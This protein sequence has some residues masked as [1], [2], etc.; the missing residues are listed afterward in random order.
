MTF[1]QGLGFLCGSLT[2]SGPF[3]KLSPRTLL[4]GGRIASGLM[5]TGIFIVP[6]PTPVAV[7]MMAL[8]AWT[9]ALSTIATTLVLANES[10]AGHAATMTLNGS[11]WSVG[12][13]IGASLGGI[14]LALGGW[15]ALGA[16]GLGFFLVAAGLGW[17]SG[18][19]PR[20]SRVLAA[21]P[22]PR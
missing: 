12:I 10:P 7:L 5:M 4:V 3:G 1:V 15:P 8:G 18:T 9:G 6:A 22:R 17:L 20:P 14:V 19:Q 21:R 16:L 11:A 13:A 2:M